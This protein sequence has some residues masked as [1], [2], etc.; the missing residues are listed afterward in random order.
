MAVLQ[1]HGLKSPIARPDKLIGIWCVFDVKIRSKNLIRVRSVYWSNSDQKCLVGWHVSSYYRNF[2]H[3]WNFLVW[4]RDRATRWQ[5][6]SIFRDPSCLTRGLRSWIS[7]HR[8][9]A[10]ITTAPWSSSSS[11]LVF[12]NMGQHLLVGIIW[13]I[14]NNC[15]VFL[16]MAASQFSSRNCA[17]G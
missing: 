10:I 5:V 3:F 6:I 1:K 2:V 11:L 16:M 13:K 7:R 14:V 9:H 17:V 8:Y 4:S 12:F 15:L